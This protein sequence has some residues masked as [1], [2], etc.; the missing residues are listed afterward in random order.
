MAKEAEQLAQWIEYLCRTVF[1]NRAVDDP[2][3]IDAQAELV[4]SL[5]R[6]EPC[7]QV[8]DTVLF[9]W[10]SGQEI[11]LDDGKERYLLMREA[12][13]LMVYDDVEVTIG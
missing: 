6:R 4:R 3:D 5:V 12:D 10:A 8:G 11:I 2:F 9:S 1:K 13:L 7:V